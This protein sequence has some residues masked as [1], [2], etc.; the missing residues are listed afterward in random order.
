MKVIAIRDATTRNIAC[1]FSIIDRNSVSRIAVVLASTLSSV[2]GRDN[3][4]YY[5]SVI[6]FRET[7]TIL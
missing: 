3:P 4:D 1:A 5:A 2:L 7:I 6:R